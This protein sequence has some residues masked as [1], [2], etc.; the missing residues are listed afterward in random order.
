[1]SYGF[2]DVVQKQ[3]QTRDFGVTLHT[4]PPPVPYVTHAQTHLMYMCVGIGCFMCGFESKGY[5]RVA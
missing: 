2:T 5:I 1:M 4:P 3:S